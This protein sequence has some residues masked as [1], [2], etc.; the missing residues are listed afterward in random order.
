MTHEHVEG[1]PVGKHPLVSQLLKGVYNQC[2][3]QLRYSSTWDVDIVVRYLQ[4]LGDNSSLPLK[5]LSQKLLLLMAL[6][7]A[8]SLRAPGFGFKIPDIPT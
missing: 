3:P 7:E 8:S 4:S 2:P 5:V 1:I 6:V